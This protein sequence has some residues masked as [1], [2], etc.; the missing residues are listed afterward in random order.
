MT[1]RTEDPPTGVPEGATQVG[2]VGRNGDG[3]NRASG[4]TVCWQPLENGVRGGK[5]F[6]LIDKV[7]A[8]PNLCAAVDKVHGNKGAAGVDHV[9]VE[10]FVQDLETNLKKLHKGLKEGTYHPQATRRTWIPKP[11][12]KEQRPLGIPTVR[13]RVAETGVAECHRADL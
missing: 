12:S 9:T 11:G 5:W 7:Y 6:S 13:D 2:S 10:M 3:P 4:Q 8:L 1:G